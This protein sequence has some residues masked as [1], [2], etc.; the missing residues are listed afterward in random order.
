M[1][2]VNPWASVAQL[3]LRVGMLPALSLLPVIGI[4]VLIVSSHHLRK[5]RNKR[6]QTEEPRSGSGD[7][8]ERR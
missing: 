1:I 7:T 5:K 6:G 4:L 3:S 8:S 2:F